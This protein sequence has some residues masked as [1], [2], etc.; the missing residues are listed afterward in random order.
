MDNSPGEPG[1][2]VGHGHVFKRPDGHKAR[3][4]G[5]GLCAVC[6]KDQARKGQLKAAAGV[7]AEAAASPVPTTA[8]LA[9]MVDTIVGGLPALLTRKPGSQPTKSDMALA[10]AG[11]GVLGS[12][13]VSLSRIADALEDGNRAVR[14]STE[15][16]TRE[17]IELPPA[18]DLAPSGAAPARQFKT[19]A[20]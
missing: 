12:L 17:A 1:M 14:E 5:P 8:D 3:C 19:V 7:L 4:G 20:D 18:E 9:N 15:A 6:S 10:L 2:N 11:V 16:L 13:A